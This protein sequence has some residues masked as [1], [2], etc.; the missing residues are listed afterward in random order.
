[1][2]TVRARQVPIVGTRPLLCLE[3]VD[4]A[5]LAYRVWLQIGEI[6]GAYLAGTAVKVTAIEISRKRWLSLPWRV[7]HEEADRLLRA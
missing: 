1:M 3:T 2:T 5:A 7:N 6:V 4:Y